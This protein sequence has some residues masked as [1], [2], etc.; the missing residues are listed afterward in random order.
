MLLSKLDDARL[1]LEGELDIYAVR[2]LFAVV[3]ARATPP[4]QVDLTNVKAIDAAGVQL[5]LWLEQHVQ[6]AG[7]RLTV[8]G[9][10][11]SVRQA[12][13]FLRLSARWAS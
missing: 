13:D 4:T 8:R 7:H 6:Q 1:V 12:L 2:D 3:T 10:G 5:L 11:G 9:A